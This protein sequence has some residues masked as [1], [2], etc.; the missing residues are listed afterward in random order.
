LKAE[1]CAA[2]AAGANG[3]YVKE[4]CFT[5]EAGASGEAVVSNEEAQQA[6]V[7]LKKI[8]VERLAASTTAGAVSSAPALKISSEDAEATTQLDILVKNQ[9]LLVKNADSSEAQAQPVALLPDA[10]KAS[11]ASS[12]GFAPESVSSMQIKIDAAS[13]KAV[14][15]VNAAKNAK[16]LGFIPVKMPTAITVSAEDASVVSESKPWWSAFA[17]G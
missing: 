13:G 7:I 16:L 3:V 8:R 17:S 15:E 11:V 2:D 10:V 12:P 5:S 4:T 14:Y 9:R 1:T 6:R